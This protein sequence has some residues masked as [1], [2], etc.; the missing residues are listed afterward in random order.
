MN[1]KTPF[2]ANSSSSATPDLQQRLKN[3]L[4]G[5]CL[6]GLPIFA[7]LSLSIE[8][9]HTPWAQVGSIK[10]TISIAMPLACGVLAVIFGQRLTEPLSTFF[11]SLQL[12][13]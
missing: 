2:A 9:T 8:M 1:S 7:C 3:F 11:E 12:P 10:L 13:F 5:V 4:I 6:T